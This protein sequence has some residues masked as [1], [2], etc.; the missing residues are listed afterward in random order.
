M[1]TPSAGTELAPAKIVSVIV[2]Y[3][4]VLQ[5]L[6]ALIRQLRDQMVQVV[7][8]DNASNEEVRADLLKLRIEGL[9][10]DALNHNAG[11]AAAQ[12]NGIQLA[13]KAG[14]DAVIFFDQDS[15][16]GP[17]FVSTLVQGMCDSRVGIAAP[18][19]Y[20]EEKDFGYPLVDILPTGRR[21]KYAPEKLKRP[22]DISVAIS[23]GMLVRRSVLEAVG[24]MDERLF[25][26]YVDTEWCLR[27]AARQISVRV[28]PLATMKHSIGEKS[29]V[30]AGLRVPVHSP[31]RR[32]Y[33]IRNAFHLMR[34]GHVPALMAGRELVVGLIHQLIIILSQ[35][36][37]WEYFIYYIRA[38]RDGIFGV[39]GPYQPR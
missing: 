18:V 12:N 10:I 26:D 28:I 21:R 16:I 9:E 4:P 13:F 22:I 34:M 32:Y 31:L 11:I 39:F 35:P 24:L 5:R 15:A 1:N 7:V 29:L 3:N 2:S 8:V 19:F 23:S 20:D 14:C 38:V 17:G 27:C 30:F 33:R 36:H 6:E 37:R 25:I